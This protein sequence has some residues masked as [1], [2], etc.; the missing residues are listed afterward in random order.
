MSI[1]DGP[2]VSSRRKLGCLL[3]GLASFVVVSFLFLLAALGH[4]ECSYEPDL[5]GCEWDE[6]RR[7][8]LFP[9]SLVVT[10]I[11]AIFVARWAAKDDE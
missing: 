10:V 1:S 7:L 8:L 9:G 3:Y 11:G 5:P 4:N 2:T 6:V